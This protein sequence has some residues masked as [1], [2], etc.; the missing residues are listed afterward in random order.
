MNPKLKLHKIP[1]IGKTCDLMPP[2]VQIADVFAQYVLW[3]IPMPG[4][5]LTHKMEHLHSTVTAAISKKLPFV[6]YGYRKDGVDQGVGYWPTRET[7]VEMDY[8]EQFCVFHHPPDGR[9]YRLHP[10]GE[11]RPIELPKNCSWVMVSHGANGDSEGIMCKVVRPRG[12]PPRLRMLW[13]FHEHG[14][15]DLFRRTK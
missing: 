3:G 12:K 4:N 13:R 5:G 6:Y 8:A 14:E 10:T 15:A 9:R 11:Q 2:T 7:L 1:V